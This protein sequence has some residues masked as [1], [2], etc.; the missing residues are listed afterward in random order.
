MRTLLVTRGLPASGK[1]TWIKQNNLTQFTLSPDSLR[2]LASSP[3][4]DIDGYL[5]INQKNDSMIWEFFYKL[6]ESRLKR[7]DFSIIDATNVTTTNLKLYQKLAHSYNYGLYV[8]D[9]SDVS[10]ET[11]VHRNELRKKQGE[12]AVSLDVLSRMK[13]RLESSSL[14][15]SFRVLKPD[16]WQKALLSPMDLSHYKKIYHIGDL[17]GCYSVLAQNLGN[18]DKDCFYIFLGDY[19]DRGIEN[20]EVLSYLLSICDLPSV[21]LLEGNHER[22]LRAFAKGIEASSKEFKFH[23]QKEIEKSNLTQ[24][25]ISRLCHK[26]KSCL[27]YRYNE[28]IV[29]CTHAGMPSIPSDISQMSFIPACTMINGIGGYSDTQRIADMFV[30]S[31][32]SN[33]YQ[34]FG[35]RNKDDLPIQINDRV[36]VCEGKVEFGG[37]LRIVCLDSNGFKCFAYKNDIF[38]PIDKQSDSLK[39]D[40]LIQ[41]FMDSKWIRHKS[42]GDISSFNFTKGAFAKGVWNSITCKARG[43]FIDVKK[44]LIVAR[45]YEKFF[46][47]NEVDSTK[48]SSLQSNLQFPVQA[49]V[50]ENGF[51]GIIAYYNDELFM[52]SKSDLNSAFSKHLSDIVSM[53]G[54]KDSLLTFFREYPDYSLI[55]EVIEPACDPHIIHYDMPKL[56]LL[57]AF[58]NDICPIRLPYNILQE[59]ANNMKIPCKKHIATLKDFNELESFMQTYSDGKLEGSYVEGFVIE[60]LTGFMFKLK[61]TYYIHWKKMRGIIASHSA[62][63]RKELNANAI[64]SVRDFLQTLCNIKQTESSLANDKDFAPVNVFLQWWAT[65][66]ISLLAKDD[67]DS[68]RQF[69]ELD[70]IS[71]RTIY[72]DNNCV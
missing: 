9:F 60:D 26:L 56:I 4:E 7:G 58:K 11:C 54:L 6:L 71:L 18:I 16:E 34:I 25:D 51:L 65:S 47:L 30:A 31:T 40:R 27:V 64:E 13:M 50:K 68:I 12:F 2:L 44:E 48:L 36:F 22:H 70:I 63:V 8:I 72:Y 24:K 35:H 38:K 45:S 57:D 32:P 37:D 46:N 17:Q 10:F 5:H 28:K 52:S 69:L 39:I 29:C 59:H 20:A 3:E 67:I 49:Y 62:K 41:E 19:I 15:N 55:F 53:L 21:W 1:S 42:F 14:S 33:Y 43:I 61:G 66:I 23:T